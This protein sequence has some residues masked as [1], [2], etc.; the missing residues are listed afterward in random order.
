MP[1]SYLDFKEEMGAFVRNAFR[2]KRGIDIGPG[3]GWWADLTG[4]GELDA[5]EIWATYV[6]E[7]DL[8]RK[9]RKVFIGDVRDFDFVGYDYAIMGDVLEHLTVGEAQLLLARLNLTLIVAV[10]FLCEQGAANGNPHEEHKQADLTPELMDARYPML[11]PILVNE[12]Y[13]YYATRL[14]DL[15]L[16]RPFPPGEWLP[17]P[18]PPLLLVWWNEQKGYGDHGL[19]DAAMTGQLWPTPRL[20][21]A[22]RRM[23]DTDN[24]GTF[25]VLPGRGKNEAQRKEVA[26]F[27]R[28]RSWTS[29]LLTSDE[30]SEFSPKQLTDLGSALVRLQTPSPALIAAGHRAMP[31]GWRMNTLEIARGIPYPAEK[32]LWAFS[33]QAGHAKRDECI[34][35]LRKL[36]QGPL[37]GALN[38]TKGFWQGLEYP[39]YLRLLS[40]ATFCPSPSGPATPDCFRTW[41]ALE[42]GSIPVVDMRSPTQSYEGWGY[43]E[44]VFGS[45]P[46]P[47][48]HLWSDFGRFAEWARDKPVEAKALSNRCSA[49]WIE[50]KRRFFLNLIKD[51]FDVSGIRAPRN[52]FSDRVTVLMPMSP[53][54]AH[55][56]IDMIKENIKRIREYPELSRA[57]IIVMC[58]GVHPRLA[59]RE[60]DYQEA[61][62]RL[63]WFA[64]RECPGLR[65]VPFAEHTHQAEMTRA[66]LNGKGGGVETPLVFF[67]EH[68]TFPVGSIP[69]DRIGKVVEGGHA[70]IKLLRLQHYGGRIHP[71]HE[72]LLA[73]KSPQ[74]VYGLPFYKTRQWSQRPHI[75]RTDFYKGLLDAHFSPG[76]RTMIEDVMHGF[77]EGAP[78]ESYGIAVYAPPGDMKRSETNDGRGADPKIVEG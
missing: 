9:Y 11:R 7:Y 62:R 25:L 5:L 68:D 63:C 18:S 60:A 4:W 69:W 50:L 61:I 53:I 78:W 20:H 75:A 30:E 39:D 13:G 33:G 26:D 17:P 8:A 2:G 56:S 64:Q 48:M 46:I 19:I 28:S 52:S 38:V 59:H 16:P 36:N 54:P 76:R 37:K 66:I 71:E 57:E 70:G 74:D 67:V 6:R 47:K 45:S 27:V 22:E 3:M 73:D 43:Y 72:W 29:V 44:Q 31:L 1:G 65:V 32:G 15:E 12:R 41:E 35:E 23:A 14:K 51:L 55:P 77:A 24:R 10:P 40:E 42:M 34:A 49:W 21:V 58:D